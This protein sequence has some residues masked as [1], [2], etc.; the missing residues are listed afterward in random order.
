MFSLLPVHQYSSSEGGKSVT[1][2]PAMPRFLGIVSSAVQ[3][4]PLP[5]LLVGERQVPVSDRVFESTS[6]ISRVPRLLASTL[7]SAR[8]LSLVRN[9]VGNLSR[10]VGDTRS[11]SVSRRHR[12]SAL[13]ATVW[14][15]EVVD[16]RHRRSP[17]R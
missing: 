16:L 3:D 4:T 7:G 5:P 2:P 17:L 11:S 6:T 15:G 12:D 8:V 13:F 9:L 10:C 14:T 1:R